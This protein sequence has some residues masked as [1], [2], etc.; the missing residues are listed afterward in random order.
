MSYSHLSK[1]ERQVVY[2]M[3]AIRKC[4]LRAIAEAL[5]RCGSTISRELRRNLD[6]RGEYHPDLACVL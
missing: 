2:V 1:A 6:S 3:R 4:S 5:G